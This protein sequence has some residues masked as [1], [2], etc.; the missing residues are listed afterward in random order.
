MR[1]FW[2]WWPR[3]KY[4]WVHTSECI[5]SQRRSCKIRSLRT[6]AHSDFALD[7]WI[8]YNIIRAN[9]YLLVF[10]R[11]KFRT[12]PAKTVVT[13][14]LSKR[15]FLSTAV[16]LRTQGA[17]LVRQKWTSGILLP[18]RQVV[19][20]QASREWPHMKPFELVGRSSE[21]CGSFPADPSE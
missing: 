14:F 20:V 8:Q 6:V 10:R 19:G 17:H 5:S 3:K 4:I 11:I 9:Q 1:M 7:Y 2:S 16:L 21:L 15:Q 18:Q 13:C 12:F